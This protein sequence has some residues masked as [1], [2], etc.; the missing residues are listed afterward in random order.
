MNKVLPY[1]EAFPGRCIELVPCVT[2]LRWLHGRHKP[3]PSVEMWQMCNSCMS[4][5][6]AW[7][8]CNQ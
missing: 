8:Q 2:A 5:E 6:T 7:H 3:R 1:F 4:H